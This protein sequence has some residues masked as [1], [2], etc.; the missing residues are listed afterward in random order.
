MPRGPAV[1][2]PTVTQAQIKRAMKAFEDLG[3]T[4]KGLR[5]NPDGS[6][7]LLLTEPAPAI[8]GDPLDAELS[9]WAKAHGYG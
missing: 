6:T 9:E 2:K 3:K 1:R 8:S 4:V 7:D 5:I